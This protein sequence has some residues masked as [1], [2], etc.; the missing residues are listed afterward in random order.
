MQPQQ[1]SSSLVLSPADILTPKELAAR[2]KVK[3]TWIYEHL[4]Q[5]S[6]DSLPG[7]RCGRYLRFNWPQVS[8]W[9]LRQPVRPAK[10]RRGS[11]RRYSA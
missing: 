4:R 2:L 10:S 6:A 9:L 11:S 8:A 7:F 3:P 1:G 5:R